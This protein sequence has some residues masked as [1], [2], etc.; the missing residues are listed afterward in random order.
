MKTESGKSPFALYHQ[1][2]LDGYEGREIASYDADY[3][4]RWKEGQ[5]DDLLAKP[6]KYPQ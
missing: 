6:S 1:G 2:Y 4:R 3:V 5:E